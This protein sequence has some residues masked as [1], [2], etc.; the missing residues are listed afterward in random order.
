MD[1]AADSN[2]ADRR[3]DVPPR[4]DAGPTGHDVDTVRLRLDGSFGP[5][6]LRAFDD[7]VEE[8]GDVG[9][10]RSRVRYR[11]LRLR[12]TP[13]VLRI[14]G[15][16]AALLAG[17]NAAPF[18]HGALRPALEALAADLS[19]P[20]PV[21]LLARVMRLDVGA[22]VPWPGPVE[23]VAGALVARPP[24][25]LVPRRPWSSEVEL[26]T[27]QFAVYDKRRER[28]RRPVHPA[29]GDGPLAR[30]E[31]RFVDD[32]DRQFRR[33]VTLGLLLDPGFFDEL[34]GRLVAEAEAAHFRRATRLPAVRVPTELRDAYAALGIAAAGGVDAAYHAVAVARAEGQLG[35]GDRATKRAYAL[36]REVDRLWTRGDATEEVDV[37]PAFR[38]AVRRAVRGSN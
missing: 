12:A 23:E 13:S 4:A 36:R 6:V 29:Y 20:L 19:I 24:A 25:R 37:G 35:E 14:E 30:V 33:P 16:L 38:K 11:N 31:L 7:Y 5:G 17:T 18:D 2:R 28:G 3:S 10:L 15:S 34:G 22:N 8:V 27:R 1:A 21:L 26:S 32:V 9:W